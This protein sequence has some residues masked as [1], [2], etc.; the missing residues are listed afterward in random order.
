MGSFIKKEWV[1]LTICI[2]LSLIVYWIWKDDFIL[3]LFFTYQ[4][5][6]LYYHKEL[7]P[8]WIEALSTLF[9]AAFA[10]IGLRIAWRSLNRDIKGQQSQI[11]T[12]AKF[13]ET[14]GTQ[15]EALSKSNDINSQIL[16]EIRKGVYE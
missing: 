9:A 2:V 10:L 13:A 1:V 6:L 15:S 14:I 4:K 7:L 16:D 5:L 11:N 3:A 12:L 8:H